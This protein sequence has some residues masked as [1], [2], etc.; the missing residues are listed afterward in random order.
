[1]ENTFFIANP[2]NLYYLFHYTIFCKFYT[3][4]LITT[5]NCNNFTQL[6]NIIE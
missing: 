2:P 4:R 5:V 3:C 1:M 6:N